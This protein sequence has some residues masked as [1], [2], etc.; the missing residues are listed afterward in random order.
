MNTGKSNVKTIMHYASSLLVIL[1]IILS[2]VI[3][4][5]L[6]S[7]SMD[8]TK[9][10]LIVVTASSYLMFSLCFMIIGVFFP[11]YEKTVSSKAGRNL[12]IMKLIAG[13]SAIYGG[14]VLHG[15][16]NI[17]QETP[18]SIK[19]HWSALGIFI[20]GIFLA[21]ADFFTAVAI[22]EPDTLN[23]GYILR[24]LISYPYGQV[25]AAQ[26]T[27]WCLVFIT[28]SV[29]YYIDTKDNIQVPH[30]VH[31]MQRETSLKSHQVQC[32]SCSTVFQYELYE[33][34]CPECGVY[35]RLSENTY[36]RDNPYK[37]KKTALELFR[38][39]GTVILVFAS[40]ITITI[41][42]NHIDTNGG[43]TFIQQKKADIS[44]KDTVSNS[45]TPEEVAALLNDIKAEDGYETIYH[46]E[47]Y[48]DGLMDEDGEKYNEVMI[49]VASDRDEKVSWY[50]YNKYLKTSENHKA[51]EIVLYMAAESD[52]LT[53]ADVISE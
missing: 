35:N 12:F 52:S 43:L 53:K 36:Y 40:I 21:F 25:L 23:I 16:H 49:L 47:L 42:K 31:T 45:F 38:A 22:T 48:T 51:G 10:T 7:Y 15:I 9:V 19:R 34:M 20:T 44:E 29:W 39:Y 28:T 18:K 24:S 11:K 17:T 33:G 50:K 30:D 37:R 4:S 14:N 3:F 1:T 46:K 8:S 5:M 32:S 2:I 41:V 6:P 26:F 27:L 13:V